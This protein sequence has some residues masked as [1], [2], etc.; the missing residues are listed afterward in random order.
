MLRAAAIRCLLC[1]LVAVLAGCAGERPHATASESRAL[2][3][4]Y[5]PPS[6][7]DREGWAADIYTPMAVLGVP[8]TPA[9]VCAIV[10][11][12]EQESGFHVDP[13]IPNL[14]GIARAEIERQREKLGIPELVLH[15]ALALQSSNGKTYRERLDHAKT[16]RDLCDIYEDFIGRVPFG[17]TLL[18]NANPV[19]TGGPMQVNV[20]FARAQ[21]AEKP[22]PYA[23][24]ESIRDEVFTRRGGMYF[25]IAH[26]LDYP[27]S[28][29][30][31]IYRF[32]DFNA[33]RYASRNAAFQNALAL[34]A[35]RKLALDGD[36]IPGEKARD[37]KPGETE[38]AALSLASQLDMGPGEIRRALELENRPELEST[39][40]YRKVFA[41]A[42]ARSAKPMARALVPTIELHTPKTNRRLTTRWFAERVE[43]RDRQCLARGR[44][45][46]SLDFG[47]AT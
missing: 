6:V 30:R 17:R 45:G 1:C 8:V 3:A 29:D 42:D 25:G 32:A 14:P 31:D 47:P 44:R 28:Y 43:A 34:L 33:G 38:S 46:A 22:Y 26:L 41:L 20:A 4:S 27:V 39:A 23:V 11:I 5:I 21:A 36:L 19:R 40:L 16:E 24:V 9:N 2:I 12:T 10:A 18:E 37:A 13:S 7:Q 35:G 15:A